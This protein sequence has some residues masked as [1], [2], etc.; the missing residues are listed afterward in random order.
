MPM[1]RPAHIALLLLVPLRALLFWVIGAERLGQL[2]WGCSFCLCCAHILLSRFKPSVPAF[3]SRRLPVRPNRFFFLR[4]LFTSSAGVLLLLA[5][6]TVHSVPFGIVFGLLLPLLELI[7]QFQTC[8]HFPLLG[9]SLA[10]LCCWG[11]SDI[12]T[13]LDNPLL[14][15]VLVCLSV[16]TFLHCMTIWILSPQPSAEALTFIPR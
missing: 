11:L 9:W 13:T 15:S 14:F 7:S 1:F 6:K 10:A 12:L 3:L 2:Q 5:G 4:A 16:G 8:R